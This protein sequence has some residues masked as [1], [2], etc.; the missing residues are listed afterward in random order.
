MKN[1]KQQNIR[2]KAHLLLQEIM[3]VNKYLVFVEKVKM[4]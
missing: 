2:E 4:H 3:Y 1:T